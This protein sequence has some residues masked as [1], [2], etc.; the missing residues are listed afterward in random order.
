MWRKGR[1]GAGGGGG[2]AGH[3]GAGMMRWL[4][5]YAD[6][7][8]LLAVFF[9]VLYSMSVMDQQK[10]IALSAALRASL[11]GENAG[12]AIIQTSPSLQEVLP[13]NLPEQQT[14]L[15]VGKELARAVQEMGL[16]HHVSIAV[17]ER[18]L[19]VSFRSEAVFF[20]L[21]RA[22]LQPALK[23]L[24]LKLAPI[25]KQIPNPIE[26]A[27][28]TDDLKIHTAEFP[29][30]WE[31]SA[32]RATNVLRFLSEEGGIPPQ[33]LHAAAFGEYHPRYPNDTEEGRARNRRVDLVVLRQFQEKE[34]PV[35][36]ILSEP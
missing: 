34:G 18:G 20:P 16:T 3:Q 36:E 2:N 17:E 12:N 35:Q 26:V 10:F 30:N 13:D 11:Y 21:G 15:E 1:G 31:L 8:T 28:Y 5:T 33:R 19:V 9:I 7:I 14:L 6:L 29:T 24:L 27:G 22:D 32:R 25:L 4:I 23:E